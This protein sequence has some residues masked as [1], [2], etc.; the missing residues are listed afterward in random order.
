MRLVGVPAETFMLDSTRPLANTR[1]NGTV[2]P[3]FAATE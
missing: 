2:A 3:W 1:S